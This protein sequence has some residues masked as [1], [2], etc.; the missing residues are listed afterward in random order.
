LPAPEGLQVPRNQN[1]TSEQFAIKYLNAI[2]MTPD[3]DNNYK[4][5]Q[6]S[7]RPAKRLS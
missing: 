4:L 7:V 1:I 5:T 6:R 3:C 2:T